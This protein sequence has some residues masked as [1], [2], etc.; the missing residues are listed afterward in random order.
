[1]KMESVAHHKPD[2]VIDRIKSITDTSPIEPFIDQLDR[3]KRQQSA[4]R[5]LSKLRLGASESAEL[6][7]VQSPKDQDTSTTR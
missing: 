1:M 7:E 4:E 2:T 5:K 6:K 3:V